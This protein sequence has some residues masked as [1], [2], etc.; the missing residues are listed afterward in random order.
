MK[1]ANAQH[2]G[3]GW[4]KTQNCIHKSCI[5]FKQQVVLKRSR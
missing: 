1:V 5:I 3:A 2:K 4:N